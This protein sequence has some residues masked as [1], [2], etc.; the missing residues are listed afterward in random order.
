MVL[1]EGAAMLALEPWDSAVAR[2]ATIHGEILGY[3]L[4]TDA[5]HIAK[6]SVEGQAAAMRAALR[7]AQLDP[8]QIDSINA[9]GTGTLANDAAET[10]AI[11][12]VFGVRAPRIPVSATK[13]MH[14]HLLGAAGALEC[15]LS[16]L[17]MQH[18]TALP[19]MHLHSPDPMCDL[20]YVP[21]AARKGA[22]GQIMLSNSFAFGGTNAVLVLGRTTEE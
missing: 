17:A 10:A 19:T 6:P 8:D 22:A 11:K 9:H 4:V 5:S 15:V 14:G 1:G 7:S 18:E 12:C 21:N 16:L 13:A 3:G 20:D 2:R